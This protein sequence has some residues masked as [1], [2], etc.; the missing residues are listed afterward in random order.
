MT[1]TNNPRANSAAM[2]NHQG[3]EEI[4]VSLNFEAALQLIITSPLAFAIATKMRQK[5][6]KPEIRIAS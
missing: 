5:P 2:F 1:F 4:L 3:E 6:N